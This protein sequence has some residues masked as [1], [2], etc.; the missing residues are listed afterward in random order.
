MCIRD[1]MHLDCF[2]NVET[3]S[4]IDWWLH[5]Q[6]S[7]ESRP[8][9]S[10]TQEGKH[11]CI[12][13]DDTHISIVSF[14]CPE[15][16]FHKSNLCLFMRWVQ[17]NLSLFSSFCYYNWLWLNT[18]HYKRVVSCEFVKEILGVDDFLTNYVV[19]LNFVCITLKNSWRS[20]LAIDKEKKDLRT[21][22][23]GGRGDFA[24]SL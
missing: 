19:Q 14:A 8:L 6:R 21:A 1:R 9:I 16:M 20:C 15:C 18:W 11:I 3:S 17:V 7:W 13:W 23:L 2:W 4:P 22:S 5:H 10:V 12:V 24:V